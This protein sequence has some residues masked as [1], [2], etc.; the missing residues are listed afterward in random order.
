M[1]TMNADTA[2][3]DKFSA[4]AAS[5]WDPMGPMRPLHAINPVRTAWIEGHMRL[6]GKRAL[7]VG[8]GGGI[9]CES[10]ARRGALVTGMDLAQAPL[11][12]AQAHATEA[13]LRIDYVQASV[14]A[15]AQDHAE[16]FELVTCMELL[17]HV[18][19]PAQ[20]VAA[21]ARLT[22]P[23]GWCFFSTINRN[24]K[25]F[26]LA[27]VAAEYILKLVPRGTHEY[28]RLIRP[29]ELARAI[30]STPLQWVEIKGLRLNPLTHN[31]TLCDDV[32]VNYLVACQKPLH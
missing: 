28:A 21:C 7:D 32:D 17:E 6:S 1:R 9:L 25:S 26:A 8:C 24:A 3:L 30:R 27:I 12:V 18:P 23:G 4:L 14:E 16:A 22:A 13:G 31:A 15:M 10:M 20:V 2:E 29:S 5:W 19:N 11:E